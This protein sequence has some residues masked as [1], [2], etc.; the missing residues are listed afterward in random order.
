VTAIVLTQWQPTWSADFAAL[1]ARIEAA[2]GPEIIRVD[3][4]GSTS[5]PGMAAK[6]C[7]DVQVIVRRLPNERLVAGC[8]LPA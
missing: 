5:V 6:D 2:V 1:A 7:I 8:R 3:H 4:I